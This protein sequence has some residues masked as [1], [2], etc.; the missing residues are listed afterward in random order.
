M[1]EKIEKTEA[2]W[3]QQLTPEQY[4]I[5]RQK[6]TERAFTGKF[7]DTKTP[8]TY[9]CAGCGQELFGSGEKFDSSCGWPS[10]DAEITGAVRHLPDPD[11]R[12]TEILCAAC[13]GHLGHVFEGEGLTPKDVRH[14]VNSLS[15][16][17]IPA[18]QS[19][20]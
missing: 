1:S 18:E 2:E 10:F 15:M 19:G 13:D 17:F 9:L 3:R 6:G 12:R 4:Q 11:G 20:T 7:W 14:C 16:R 5:L 8:G